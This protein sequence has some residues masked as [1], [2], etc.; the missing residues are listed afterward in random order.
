[1]P[2]YVRIDGTAIAN[3][4]Q[5]PTRSLNRRASE[6]T[7]L[8]RAARR[9]RQEW[10][11]VNPPSRRMFQARPIDLEGAVSE[12]RDA[13]EQ[14]GPA[15]SGVGLRPGRRDSL[16]DLV[17]GVYDEL[18]SIARRQLSLRAPG[19]TLSTTGLVH[20]AYLRLASQ[21]RVTWRD[22][23]H[24]F[25]LASVA[26]RH[27]LVDRARARQASKREGTLKRV[28][29]D[30]EQIAAEDQAEALLLLNDAIDRLAAVEPRLARV[31]D[32]RFFGD[33]SDGETA[34]SLGVTPRT[35]QCDWGKARMFLRQALAT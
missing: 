3:R 23:G 10:G 6:S 9:H 13:L 32:C 29:L 35:V 25:A 16:D 26:M 18:R 8:G 17:P 22:R 31:V 15:T 30:S 1:M 14:A 11:M 24:L 12:E 27:V 5:S 33:T 2:A 21:S 4:A 19:G 28:P 7:E 20:E 34:A